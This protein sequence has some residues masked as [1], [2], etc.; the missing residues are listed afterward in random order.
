M[1][2]VETFLEGN[3]RRYTVTC[4]VL[5][6]ALFNPATMFQVDGLNYLKTN[7]D[8]A[9]FSRLKLGDPIGNL[10]QFVFGTDPDVGNPSTGVFTVELE[11]DNDGRYT[12][13]FTGTGACFC[14]AEIDVVVS[15]AR[16][17]A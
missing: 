9:T 4:G 2:I 11:Y 12:V 13:G 5:T 8:T 16:A 6:S 1:A 7:P 15:N 14:Y 10:E 3:R 17:R